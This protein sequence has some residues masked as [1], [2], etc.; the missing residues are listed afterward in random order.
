[1][2]ERAA[3][4]RRPAFTLIELLVVIAIIGVLMA[5]LLPAVQNARAAARRTQCRNHL[6][7]LILAVHNYM[8]LHKEMFVPYSVDD[9][10]EI[11]YVLNGFSGTRGHIQ[12]WFGDTDNNE[13]NPYRQLDFEKGTLAPFMEAVR[14]AYQCPDFG[15]KQVSVVRFGQMASGYAY[16]GY[17]LG[18][19]L[20]YDYS[21]WPAINVSPEPIVQKMSDL[22]EP[23]RTVAFADS[24]QVKC[25]NWPTCSD[26]SVEEN[27]LI[28]PPSNQFPTI[29]FRHSS[30]ANVAFADGHVETMEPKWV[31]LP[32]V[33]A[34]QAAH[35][36]KIGLG[37]VSED[38]SL[39]DRD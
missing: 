13:P 17:A 16:N 31:D 29:H 5:L 21:A 22:R 2:R 4:R 39:Y 6:K 19:G 15:D 26:V 37:H 25:L 34:A 8:D 28:E 7:Q 35:M 32:F 33:P 23:T 18:R 11:Q 30:A 9:N 1:M 36:Q 38:D 14:A 20:A 27:W 24:A 3:T 10:T 12:Y